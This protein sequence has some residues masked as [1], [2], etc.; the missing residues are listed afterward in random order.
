M[1]SEIDKKNK[2]INENRFDSSKYELPKRGKND[3]A[4]YCGQYS[5][6]LR[7][8]VRSYGLTKVTAYIV[9]SSLTL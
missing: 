2:G 8:K 3:V 6:Y 9:Y 4:I 1:Q 5:Y 7:T